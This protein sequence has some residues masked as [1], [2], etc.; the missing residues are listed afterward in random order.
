MAQDGWRVTALEPD[1]SVL[2][3]SGAIREIAASTGLSIEVLEAEGEH[4]PLESGSFDLVVARQALHHAANLTLLAREIRRVL[5]PGGTLVALRDHVLVDR[6]DL[7]HF[8][9]SHPLHRYYGGEN[10]Y[11]LDEYVTALAHAGFKLTEVFGPTGSDITCFPQSLEDVRGLVAKRL[12]I[13]PAWLPNAIVGAIGHFRSAP[14]APY[15]FVAIAER[16]NAT[17]APSVRAVQFVHEARRWSS[18]LVRTIRGH[19]SV[20]G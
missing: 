11:T 15:A 18:R 1:P 2:V 20:G 4:M 5:R 8:L 7:A 13:S 6:A 10:A 9:D 19:A 12:G 14:G 17:P 16:P 3:G